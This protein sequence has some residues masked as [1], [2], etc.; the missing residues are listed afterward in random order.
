MSSDD[1]DT[2]KC[3]T[4][5]AVEMSYIKAVFRHSRTRLAADWDKVAEEVNVK[6]AKC[7]RERFRQIS[8]KHSLLGQ[9]G[10]SPKK[11][12][13]ADSSGKVTKK[14]TP[15]VKKVKKEEGSEPV[16]APVEDAVN[17]ES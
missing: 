13:A 3:L 9:E 6:D 16:E 17:A 15:R 1:Q 8:V 10:G 12:G 5:A 7:A 2:P 11:G 4:L 14:R